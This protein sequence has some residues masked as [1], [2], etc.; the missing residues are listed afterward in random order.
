MRWRRQILALEGVKGVVSD[1]LDST[2]AGFQILEREMLER[3]LQ[4]MYDEYVETGYVKYHGDDERIG[5][6]DQ[7]AM[8][9]HLARGLDRLCAADATQ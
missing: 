3:I 1:L 7:R 8:C 2:G 9:R 4:N 5:E 6:Y